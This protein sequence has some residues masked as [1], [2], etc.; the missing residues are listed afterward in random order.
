MCR[1][2]AYIGKNP[3]L[4]HH[5][6]IDPEHSLITQSKS[7][8]EATCGVNADGFGI[9]WYNFEIDTL[10][11][12]FKSTLP[13]WNDENLRHL[14]RKICSPCFVGHVR[15]STVA[16]V[17]FANCH[18][19]S[20]EQLLFVHNGTIHHFQHMKKALIEKISSK[21]LDNIKGQTDSEYFFALLCTLIENEKTLTEDVL[22]QCV[23]KGLSCINQLQKENCPEVNSNMNVLISNG[24][25]LVASKYTSH[26]K[27]KPLS[28][29]YSSSFFGEGPSCFISSEILN[30]DKAHWKTV[31]KNHLVSVNGAYEIQL[32]SIS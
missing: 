10:P 21:H 1:F 12:L 5:I 13:A 18:P 14:T 28:L 32:T 19:F 31:P 8:K 22:T 27:E 3:F 20:F 2:T 29:Y 16:N 11:A 4:L 23:L 15:A 30:N 26:S 6:L 7:A 25:L 24:K 17:D 9:G